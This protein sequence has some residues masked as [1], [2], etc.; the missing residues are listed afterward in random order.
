MK[1]SACALLLMATCAVA[2]AH[3]IEFWHSSTVFA[4]Q[5][6]CS[7]VFSFDSGFAA[8][9]NL[10]VSVSAIDRSGKNV[11]S[12]TLEIAEFGDSSVARYADAYLE[13]EGMCADDLTIVVDKATATIGGKV[14]DLLENK[15]LTAREFKPYRIRIGK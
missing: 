7:A 4:N 15:A 13:G 3:A 11:N 6:Q 9:K 14:T 8:V 1:R 2:P 5:G 12:G 10:R